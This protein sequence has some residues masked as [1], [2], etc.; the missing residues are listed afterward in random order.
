MELKTKTFVFILVSF[1]L[2]GIA[3][4]FI[5]RTY[6]ASQPNMHRPSR[7]DVQEQF[8][9]RLQLTPEQATQVDSIFEAYRKNFGDFQ[10]QYWQT[11]RFKR[12]TLRLEIRRLLSEEQNKLYEGYIKE[13]EE[14][15]GRR[16]GGRER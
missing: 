2:G 14:R 7:A 9:E 4:G 3:G 11:F 6:F 1:L 10:K 15:E 5:G 12:D 8:A 16:R 13:M